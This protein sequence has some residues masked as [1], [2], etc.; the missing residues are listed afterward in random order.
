MYYE[1]NANESMNPENIKLNISEG[2]GLEAKV[3]QLNK[4]NGKESLSQKLEPFNNAAIDLK[5]SQSKASEVE[6]KSNKHGD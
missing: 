5:M 1:V 4:E 2:E 6:D 3:A